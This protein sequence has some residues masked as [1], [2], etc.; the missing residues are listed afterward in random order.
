MIK[1]TVLP[2]KLEMTKYTITPHAGLALLGELTVG[3][4]LDKALD[5]HLPDAGSGAG[6][7]A[8]EHVFP[9]VLMLNGGDR[10]L[11]CSHVHMLEKTRLIF[12]ETEELP[13]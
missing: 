10:S 7:L 9:L 6:Y 1:Q 2:F 3:L 11:E 12:Q 8:N 5:R 13:P 4:G